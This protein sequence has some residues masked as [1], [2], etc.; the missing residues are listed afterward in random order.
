MQELPLIIRPE[1]AGDYAA[2]RQVNDL[3]FGQPN[4]GQLIEELH[5][6][7]QFIPELSLLRF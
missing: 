1:M 4:E 2:I 3:A 6:I 5:L 7:E